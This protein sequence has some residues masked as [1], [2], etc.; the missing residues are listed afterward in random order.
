MQWLGQDHGFIRPAARD[1]RMFAVCQLGRVCQRALPF[2][3]GERID[4]GKQIYAPEN[5]V[6]FQEA[7]RFRNRDHAC[8]PL[9]AEDVGGG[10]EAGVFRYRA[11]FLARF[12]G[13]RHR[14]D[15]GEGRR[16]RP[17]YTGRDRA[18]EIQGG[19]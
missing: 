14:E 9:T 11:V 3:P 16:R 10:S 19:H 7:E 15:K 6:P 5:Q 12:S 1:A 17:Q 8:D 4:S 13:T 18:T 2:Q